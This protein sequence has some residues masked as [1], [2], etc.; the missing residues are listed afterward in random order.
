MA[1]AGKRPPHVFTDDE[2]ARMREAEKKQ[3]EEERTYRMQAPRMRIPWRIKKGEIIRVL[4]K[5]RHPNRTGLRMRQDGSFVRS[6]PA[7]YIRL[8]EVFYGGEL[9]T[10]LE[11][12]S[13]VGDDPIFGF[14]L[15]ADKEA[16]LRVVFTNHRDERSEAVKRV[17]FAAD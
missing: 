5:I 12:N 16:P 10:K 4:V 13:A 2:M 8:V 15:R 3:I 9:V 1:D 11:P 7:F 17:A 14:H 6:R